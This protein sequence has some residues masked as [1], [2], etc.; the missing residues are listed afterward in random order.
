MEVLEILI[1]FYVQRFYMLRIESAVVI[2]V[3]HF[4][5]I[6]YQNNKCLI[7]SKI[8]IWAEKKK[9]YINLH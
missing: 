6:V 8:E 7:I 9:L 5:V 3:L 2:V 1:K 4:L